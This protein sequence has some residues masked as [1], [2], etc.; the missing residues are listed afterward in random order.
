MVEQ[1]QLDNTMIE[2]DGTENKC[3]SK[4]DRMT[5]TTPSA[6]TSQL[7]LSRVQQLAHILKTVCTKG[8]FVT[9]SFAEQ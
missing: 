7:E 1:E 5:Y 6:C 9:E 8:S 2:M 3:E 4:H